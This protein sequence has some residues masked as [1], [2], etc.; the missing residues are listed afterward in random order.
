MKTHIASPGKRVLVLGA[1]ELLLTREFINLCQ[2]KAFSGINNFNR[3]NE[4]REFF[5]QWHLKE[6]AKKVNKAN[7]GGHLTLT[8]PEVKTLNAMTQRVEAHDLLQ[9]V[10]R[11]IKE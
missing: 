4:T 11:R 1:K 3:V 2:T 9:D 8:C 10:F 6:I 5:Y 7:R